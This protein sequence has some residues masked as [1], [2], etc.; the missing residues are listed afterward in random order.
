[1]ATSL[2]YHQICTNSGLD[3]SDTRVGNPELQKATIIK[4]DT[5]SESESD[6]GDLHVDKIRPETVPE[7][8]CTSIMSP[9]TEDGMTRGRSGKI[10]RQLRDPS[11]SE[12][13]EKCSRKR[14]RGKTKDREIEKVSRRI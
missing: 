13:T 12:T 10:M 1:M 7:N 4:Q 6:K 8:S 14:N 11:A 5:V 3:F 2:G 9:G